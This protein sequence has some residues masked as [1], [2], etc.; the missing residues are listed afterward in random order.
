Q[1]VMSLFYRPP[2]G[3][4]TFIQGMS[5]SFINNTQIGTELASIVTGTCDQR[6]T[7]IAPHLTLG[8][9][10]YA[11]NSGASVTF[12]Q[13]RTGYF[14]GGSTIAHVPCRRTSTGAEITDS[15]GNILVIAEHAAPCIDIDHSFSNLFGS[16][17][18]YY[19]A[20]D[21]LSAP[22]TT[23]GT[24]RTAP[25][26]TT[27]PSGA[28]RLLTDVA[29]VCFLEDRAGNPNFG[30]WLIFQQTAGTCWNYQT[31]SS[32]YNAAIYQYFI[33]GGDLRN[34]QGIVL[35]NPQTV[36]LPANCNTPYETKFACI[37]NVWYAAGI[38]AQTYYQAG[39]P[40]YFFIGSGS[41]PTSITTAVYG[42]ALPGGV[43]GWDGCGVE[44]CQGVWYA[45]PVDSSVPSTECWLLLAATE[46]GTLPFTMTLPFV[47][48]TNLVAYQFT[49][50]NGKPYTQFRRLSH[51]DN[52]TVWGYDWSQ[53]GVTAGVDMLGDLVT[54]R[55]PIFPGWEFP[56]I[57]FNLP[58][59]YTS[60]PIETGNVNPFDIDPE[61]TT[62]I[63][64]GNVATGPVESKREL[65]N[66]TGRRLLENLTS[67][68]LLEGFSAG[69]SGDPFRIDP[70][71]TTL[72]TAGNVNP[73]DID[74]EQTTII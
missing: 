34:N 18:W 16:T 41:S 61:Q 49:G 4:D 73:F 58:Y 6:D 72:I 33:Y 40:Q 57:S 30:D 27:N 43:T 37:N 56:P 50:A 62:L 21:M 59:E 24:V 14:G 48:H 54:N 39:S 9:A 15:N 29:Q 71:Q 55:S 28:V 31:G 65:Q 2:A 36:N 53:G 23:F 67:Y 20:T 12:S 52:F 22:L 7:T 44:R 60:I 3:S 1:D 46:I 70:E 68:R 11:A 19:P 25:Y 5:S 74:P 51:D 63:T 26:T 42:P 69:S 13:I 64:T 32:T 47:A 38:T 17:H 35:T 66:L 45:T 10:F 8:L